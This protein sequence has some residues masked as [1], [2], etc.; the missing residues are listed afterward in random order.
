MSSLKCKES[1]V[2]GQ[3]MFHTNYTTTWG[4]LHAE[5]NE[6]MNRLFIAL[7]FKGFTQRL[8]ALSAAL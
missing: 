2:D 8:L 5:R 1:N 3:D 4:A 7:F 6:A